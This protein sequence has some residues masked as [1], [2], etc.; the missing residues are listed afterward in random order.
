M[1]NIFL[2]TV[3]FLAVFTCGISI[4]SATR[5]TGKEVGVVIIGGAEFKTADYYKMIPQSFKLPR[6]YVIGDQMQSRY[7]LF[8]MENDLLDEKIPRK[9]Y[10]LDFTARSGCSKVLFLVVDSATDHQNNPKTRQKNRLTVQVD[11]YLMDQFK[12][13]AGAGSVQESKSKTSDL[14]ARREAFKKCLTELAKYIKLS[15]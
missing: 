5:E 15:A 14:R 11:A 2:A 3:T 4:S 7:Q 13:I 9:N 10:L 8:L 12:I 1:K 6:G